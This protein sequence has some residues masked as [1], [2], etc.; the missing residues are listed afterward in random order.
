[1]AQ[2]ATIPALQNLSLIALLG[3]AATITDD[4][5]KKLVNTLSVG[6]GTND[7]RDTYIIPVN[8]EPLTLFPSA[9]IGLYPDLGG[10]VVE[11]NG[12]GTLIVEN[13]ASDATVTWSQN[14]TTI[15]LTAKSGRETVINADSIFAKFTSA[16]AS[17]QFATTNCSFTGQGYFVF[18]PL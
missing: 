3:S 12:S 18:Y 6:S 7:L 10:R 15:T 17:T 14:S 11:Y 13:V 9:I 5:L 2:L 4:K 8:S 16:T 1:M